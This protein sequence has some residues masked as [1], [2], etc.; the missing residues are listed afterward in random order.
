M[1]NI[2]LAVIGMILATVSMYKISP[3]VEKYIQSNKVESLI[4]KEQQI[5]DAAKRYITTTGSI[6]LNIEVLETAGY[7]PADLADDNGW[8]QP[9]TLS[10]TTTQTNGQIAIN[11]TIPNAYAKTVYLRSFKKTFTATNPSGDDTVSS[12][13]LPIDVLHGNS[14]G[15]FSG[16]IA[17]A[18][19]PTGELIK[20]WYD[21]SDTT[22]GAILKVKDTANGTWVPIATNNMLP[23]VSSTNT[24][25]AVGSLPTTDVSDGDIRYVYNATSGAVDTYVYYGT[26]WQKYLSGSSATLTA[27]YGQY[28]KC[29]DITTTGLIAY[30]PLTG[31]PEAWVGTY[32]GT[33]YNSVLYVNDATKGG[34]ASFN[35]DDS[36]DYIDLNIDNAVSGTLNFWMYIPTQVTKSSAA[37]IIGMPNRKNSSN[38]IATGEIGGTGTDETFSFYVHDMTMSWYIKDNIP[39]GW[40]MVTTFWDGGIWRIYLDGVSKTVYTYGTQQNITLDPIFGRRDYD[41]TQDFNGRIT[42]IRIYNRALSGTEIATIYDTESTKHPIVVDSGLIAYYKLIRNSHDHYYN[43]YNGTDTSVTYSDGK[44]ATFNGSS[45]YIATGF[46]VPANTSYGFSAWIKTTNTS[47]TMII[48]SDTDSN[49]ANKSGRAVLGFYNGNFYFNMGDNTNAWYDIT[50]YNSASVR[51][52][53]WHHLYLATDGTS[54]KLYVDGVL[55]GSLTST[56]NPGTIGARTYKIGRAGDYSG[57]YFNGSIANVRAYNRALSADDV[58]SIYDNEKGEV[59]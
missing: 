38:W 17:S 29:S 23:R 43:Q 21:T 8:G 12:F 10:T 32:H 2:I 19:A 34:V 20:Y 52:G 57:G 28:Y 50:T 40:H 18:T 59:E 42:N 45:S 39:A 54:Q 58:K 56:V 53:A 16:A 55:F 35:G 44:S 27:C 6:P 22:K 4:Q 41:K 14:G 49:G 7:L 47:S 51:D 13:V 11:T 26:G 25:A 36:G 5:Y 48:F 31:K 9:I 1:Q 30:Y 24:V 46:T 33:E 15:V 37:A 3:S